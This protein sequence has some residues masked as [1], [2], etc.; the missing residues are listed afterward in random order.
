MRRVELHIKTPFADGLHFLLI[1]KYLA[2]ATISC[3]LSSYQFQS[4]FAL[5]FIHSRTTPLPRWTP[6]I[7]HHIFPSKGTS[8][9]AP[10]SGAYHLVFS[11]SSIFRFLV[12]SVVQ[13]EA[14]TTR[15]ERIAI[16]RAIDIIASPSSTQ[17]ISWLLN[18]EILN[19]NLQP[20]IYYK[21]EGVLVQSKSEP[22]V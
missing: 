2:R 6:A 8:K 4:P 21:S 22:R 17:T 10:T 16:Y 9:I 3:T 15:I 18:F 14:P 5:G 20:S 12:A 1:P 7:C 13:V 19:V 11:T